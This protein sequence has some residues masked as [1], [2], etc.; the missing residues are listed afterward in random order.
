MFLGVET[1]ASMTGKSKYH[2]DGYIIIEDYQK[3]FADTTGL[4]AGIGDIS[5]MKEAIWQ[6]GYDFFREVCIHTPELKLLSND[7]S[8]K[9]QRQYRLL[10]EQNFNPL[11]ATRGLKF[12]ATEFWF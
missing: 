5:S 8:S 2:A 4:C 6:I 9:E 10:M 3:L 12:V 1:H 11:L 7:K